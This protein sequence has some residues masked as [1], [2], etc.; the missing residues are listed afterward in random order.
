MQVA[1]IAAL[2]HP[3]APML[4]LSWLVVVLVGVACCCYILLQ[5]ALMLDLSFAP[6]SL[7]SG[8]NAP[9]V[10][11]VVSPITTCAIDTISLISHSACTLGDVTLC[12][13]WWWC[14][15]FQTL[16]YCTLC[17]DGLWW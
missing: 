8:T 2:C 5:L 3:A 14:L 12:N 9:L 1:V 10:H 13:L 16:V 4:I 6:C 7:T 11:V 15:S 17:D